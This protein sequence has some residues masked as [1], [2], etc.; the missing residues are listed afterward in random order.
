MQL[1]RE[2]I[3]AGD[4]KAKGL[5]TVGTIRK[6]ERRRPSVVLAKLGDALVVREDLVEEDVR[7][8][9][10]DHVFI[11]LLRS[12]ETLG[13]GENVGKLVARKHDLAKVQFLILGGTAG[14][15]KRPVGSSEEG[16]AEGSKSVKHV[17]YTN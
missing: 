7:D 12:D 1:R 16:D 10:L 17:R 3:V 15:G 6:G 14:L 5:A 11:R 9:L 13:S 4:A 8:E 2:H